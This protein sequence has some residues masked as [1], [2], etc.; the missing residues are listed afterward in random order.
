MFT[1]MTRPMLRI[2]RNIRVQAAG[3]LTIRI[4]GLHREPI[5]EEATGRG[6]ARTVQGLLESRAGSRRTERRLSPRKQ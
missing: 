4:V 6:V 5:G 1:R 2:V 3:S